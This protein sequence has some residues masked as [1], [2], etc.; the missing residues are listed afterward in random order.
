VRFP[1]TMLARTPIQYES[2]YHKTTY[3]CRL[4]VVENPYPQTIGYFDGI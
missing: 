2:I 1:M 3:Y 4:G